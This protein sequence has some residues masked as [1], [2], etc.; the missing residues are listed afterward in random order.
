[1]LKMKC[2]T[3]CFRVIKLC[4]ILLSITYF[5]CSES[6]II[7]SKKEES[8][9]STA[10]NAYFKKSLELMEMIETKTDRLFSIA[11]K[12]P[13]VKHGEWRYFWPET[14]QSP[15][16]Y[17]TSMPITVSD[18]RDKLYIKPIGK[19]SDHDY[20]ILK[21][22]REY[23]EDNFQT[24]VVLLKKEN[25]F[26]P[27]EAVRRNSHGDEQYSSVY[28][29]DVILKE[30]LPNDGWGILAVTPDDIYRAEGIDKLYG[31]T[32]IF[33]RR[34][35][36]SLYHLKHGDKTSLSLAL[37]G[38]SHEASHLLSLPHCSKYKCNMN[39]RITIEEFSAAP[40]HYS[41]DC[42]SKI[43]FATG[44]NIRKRFVEL[45]AFCKEND[46]RDELDYYSRALTIID[47]K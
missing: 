38:A 18:E 29:T 11:Q 21:K 23:L 30:D 33:G 34:G 8:V 35:V 14:E 2:F 13:P 44:G 16:K 42:L 12:M 43:I 17:V 6:D 31:D 9:K 39:G 47:N 7:D 36:I 37:K 5:G 19:F 32:L 24:P 25:D 27:K 46:L 1:M 4:L 20:L 40:L 10:N 15:Q 28:I 3:Y 41:P 22:I 45:I 26:F